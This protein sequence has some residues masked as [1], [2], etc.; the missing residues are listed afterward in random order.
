MPNSHSFEQLRPRCRPPAAAGH[1]S[2]Y[3]HASLSIVY[4]ANRIQQWPSAVTSGFQTALPRYPWTW[5]GVIPP[6]HHRRCCKEA[7]SKALCFSVRGSL[8]YVSR[9]APEISRFSHYTWRMD[10]E[11]LWTPNGSENGIWRHRSIAQHRIPVYQLTVVPHP[12]LTAGE[13]SRFFRASRIGLHVV[14]TARWRSGRNQT[15]LIDGLT[16]TSFFESNICLVCMSNRCEAIC[17]LWLICNGEQPK[18]SARDLTERKWRRGSIRWAC[19]RFSSASN[20]SKVIQPFN[21]LQFWRDT[22]RWIFRLYVVYLD[23]AYILS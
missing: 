2:V 22:A 20:R 5:R 21:G 14:R 19:W 18:S 3:C 11:Q 12:S 16:T 7:V 17:V 8:L 9:L 13:F 15:S 6:W 4:L 23:E 10:S 1:G